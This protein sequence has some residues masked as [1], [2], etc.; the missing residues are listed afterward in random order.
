[1]S[2]FLITACQPLTKPW[3]LP[4][5]I[6]AVVAP[7]D[8][9][10]TDDWSPGGQWDWWAISS[11]AKS[12][13]LTRSEHDGDDRLVTISTVP[14]RKAELDALG[15]LECHGGPRG[16]LDFGAC[17]GAR[18]QGMMPGSTPGRN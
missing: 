4:E 6:A 14:R 2:A 18:R 8:A 11:D 3:M 5:A 9:N 12:S 13:Y 17:G 1:M 16:L 7:Y 10:L 15:P